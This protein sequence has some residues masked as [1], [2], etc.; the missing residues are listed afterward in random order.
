MSDVEVDS[1]PPWNFSWVV[2]NKLAAMAY[3]RNKEN[4]KYL[5][6]EGIRHLVTLSPEKKPPIREYPLLDWTEIPCDEFEAP[7]LKDIKDFVELCRK[8]QVKGQVK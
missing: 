8:C 2:P 6:D 5:V 1:Y 4:L 7:T 3:P